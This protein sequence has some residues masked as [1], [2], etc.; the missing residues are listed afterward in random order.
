MSGDIPRLFTIAPDKPFLEVL[1]AQVLKGFPCTDG[2][3]PGTLGLARWTILLPT[4]RAVRELEEIFFRLTGGSGVLLPRIRPIGDIDEDLLQPEHGVEELGTPVSAPGQLLLLMDLIDEWAAA[5]PTT[6]LAQEIAAAPHQAGGLAQSLAELLDALETEDVDVTRIAE[7]YGLESA[8]HREAILEFLAIARETYPQRLAQENAMGP[9]A[10]RSAILKREARRLEFTRTGRPFIV[11][12]STGSIPATCTLLKA[13]AG[14]PNGA[15][16]LPGLDQF[17]DEASWTAVGPTHPQHA[18]KQLLTRLDAT[19][20]L[21]A[22]L[23]GAPGPRAWLASELMRP[24]ETSH[25]WHDAL[26]GQEARV[27]EAMQGVE[28][29]ESR[30]VPEQALAAALILRE[31]LETPGRNACLVTPDRQLA[32]RVKAELRRWNIAIDD[33][34][35]EPL[36]RFGGAAL[37]NLLLEALLQGFAAEPLAAL[38]RH[39]LATFGLPPDE[40]R[41]LASLIELALLRTGTGAPEIGK[42]SHALRIATETDNRRALPLAVK[43]VTG[44]QWQQAIAQ[45]SRISDVLAPLALNPPHT[46]AEHLDRLAKACEAMAGEAFWA[47]EGGD[48]LTGAFA[49]L[50]DESRF[51][52]R[53]DLRRTAAILRH[54]LHGLP[55]RNQQH[56]PTPLSIL[57]LLEARLIRADVMVLAGLNEGTWPGA[58]DCGPWLNRPMR[59]VLAMKQPEAQIG[60]TAHDFAQAFGNAEVKLLWSRRIGDAPGTPSRWLHRLLMILETAKLERRP[61]NWPLYARQL[62]EP[63]AVTPVA[64][65]KPRPP[66]ALRPKALSVTRIEKLIR[67]PYAIYARFILNVEPVKPV[68]SVP[69]LA[70]RGTIVHAAIGDFLNR[71]PKHLPADAAGE[72]E[73][74]GSRHFQQIADYPGVVSFWWPRFRRI[75][76]WMA[77]QEPAWRDGVECVVAE[78]NGA[79]TFPVAGA[80]FTLS[81][82]VD[83]IDLMADG[84]A[85]IV[86]YKTGDVPTKKQVETGLAPQLTLQAA[87][88]ARGG[89]SDVAPRQTHALWYVHLS[90]GSPAGEVKDFPKLAHPVMELAEMHFAELQKLLANYASVEQPYYPRTIMKK[91][92]DPGDYD[93][94]S[95]YREW[96]LSGGGT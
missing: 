13:I 86:D 70:R 66:V 39:G 37:L 76:A 56:N 3:V 2:T 6:R 23:G 65:P 69:D 62:S 93:H 34:G 7:L 40:A 85:R 77:E 10:R 91:E 32:R 14:L 95:R 94:L 72:L 5:N 90:G 49:L 96:T 64:K 8:R 26:K 81:A 44:E 38:L 31:C 28:L 11:A 58:T 41:H 43:H 68:S 24:A 15:V 42:L 79:V 78:R 27:A 53:C 51:L 84:A 18:I 92:E 89:F 52:R 17:M 50:R 59:D 9:Q 54:W 73:K 83:R 30:S 57:G 1:A 48:V 61:S 46:L 35:G 29:V 20:S 4:R 67:D 45:A 87:I 75:A 25:L 21:V 19:R 82:R 47:G 33:S 22:E 55:V 88:L 71:F 80:D 63:A 16:V 12:G 74:D 36:I 60:Q